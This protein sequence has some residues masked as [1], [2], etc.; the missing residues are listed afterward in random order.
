MAS[1]GF[2]KWLETAADEATQPAAVDFD[3]TDA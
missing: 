3:L 1:Q 2:D